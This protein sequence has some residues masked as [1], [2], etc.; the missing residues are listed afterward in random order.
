MVLPVD[1]ETSCLDPFE[2]GVPKLVEMEPTKKSLYDH[3]NT[4]Y[5]RRAHPQRAHLGYYLLPPPSV[6]RACCKQRST[7]V[8]SYIVKIIILTVAG[9]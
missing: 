4:S 9:R 6:K 1:V 8:K 5:S 7:A 3:Q 2:T